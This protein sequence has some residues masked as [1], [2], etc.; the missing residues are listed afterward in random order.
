MNCVLLLEIPTKLVRLIKACAQKSKCKVKFNGEL[1]DDFSVETGLRQGDALSP[2][3]FNI[4]LESVMREGLDDGTGLR[5]GEGHQI[6]LAA[7]ADDIVIIGET[8][9]DLK[10]LAE[11][12]ISKGKE[13]GLQVNEEKNEIS[14]SVT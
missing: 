4:D 14:N 6:K 10:R 11:K 2:T 8:E 3:L 1:S 13:I 5:I 7:Y 12:L 9:E